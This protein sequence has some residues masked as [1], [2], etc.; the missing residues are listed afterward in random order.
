MRPMA[1]ASLFDATSE[2]D[3][4]LLEENGE[5][6]VSAANRTSTY[7]GFVQ[8]VFDDDDGGLFNDLVT[9]DLQVNFL[10]LM[11]SLAVRWGDEFRGEIVQCR[12]A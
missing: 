10:V 5:Y 2:N 11:E 7:R 6:F 8:A 12:G 1:S 3:F 9:G 4:T